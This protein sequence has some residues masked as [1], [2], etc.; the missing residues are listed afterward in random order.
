M[1]NPAFYGLILAGILSLGM[2]ILTEVG[3][4]IAI[5]RETR[6]GKDAHKG[7]GVTDGAVFGLLGLLIGFTFSGAASRFDGRRHLITEEANDIGT[8]YLRINLL[9]DQ[10]QPAL[11]QKFQQYLDSRLETYRRLP[12]LEAAFAELA[13]SKK[14]QDEIWAYS[15]AGCRD[16]GSQACNML[17]LPALNSMFDIVTTRT[18]ATK[19]HPP[20]IIFGMIVVLSLA[21][22]LLAGYGMAGSKSR[23]WVHIA[24]L[25]AVMAFAVVRHHGHRIP[26]C[27]TDQ[28]G[29]RRPGLG[30]IETK[31]EMTRDD[32]PEYSE[33][34]SNS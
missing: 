27:R 4:R 31:H 12:D 25:A 28:R 29:R 6:D 7:L 16:S 22:A 33:H 5:R 8:A 14:I 17:L 13:N 9:P 24:G 32:C 20:P 1:I 2:V 3:R 18:E 34:H 30:G 23:S 19:I 21:G 26:A 11:R 15:V 10:A